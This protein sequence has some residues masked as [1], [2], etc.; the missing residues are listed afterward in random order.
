MLFLLSYFAAMY[1]RYVAYSALK[2]MQVRIYDVAISQPHLIE[3][4]APYDWEE[5][6]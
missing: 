6:R 3:T 5:S 4:Y 2:M 1:A